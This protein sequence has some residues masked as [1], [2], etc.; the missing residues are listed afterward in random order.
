MAKRVRTIV[1][2]IDDLTGQELPE[3][4][5]QTVLYSIDGKHYE[6]DLSNQTADEFRT[7]LSPIIAKSR[8]AGTP[9]KSL[10]AAR[11]Q[12]PAAPRELTAGGDGAGSPIYPPQTKRAAWEFR[13]EIRAWARDQGIFQAESGRLKEEVV[14]AWNEAHPDRPFQ[15]GMG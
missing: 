15:E 10:P 12:R 3:G 9:A 13:R 1:T 4:D 6:I 14:Q 8:K 2:Y 5:G 11:P 7:L